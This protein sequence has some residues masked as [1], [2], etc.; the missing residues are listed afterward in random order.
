MDR[1]YKQKM[2]NLQTLGNG[3]CKFCLASTCQRNSAA[4]LPKSAPFFKKCINDNGP[5]V[6]ALADMSAK[7]VCFF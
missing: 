5:P 7:N 1:L 3:F 6:K 2:A 4:F